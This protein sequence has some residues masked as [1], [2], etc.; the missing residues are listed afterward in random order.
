MAAMAG[1]SRSRHTGMLSIYASYASS[2]LCIAARYIAGG[3]ERAEPYE[4][5]GVRAESMRG[6]MFGGRYKPCERR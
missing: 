1:S 4:L 3:G 2:A 6:V 5:Y